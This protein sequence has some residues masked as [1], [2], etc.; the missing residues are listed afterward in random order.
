MKPA[1]LFLLF[2]ILCG[3]LTHLVACKYVRQQ[4]KNTEKFIHAPIGYPFE[5]T[6]PRERRQRE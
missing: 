6:T 3:Y 2:S 4:V 5:R 1:S